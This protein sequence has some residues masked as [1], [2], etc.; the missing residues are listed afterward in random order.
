MGHLAARNAPG[1]EAG[2]ACAPA[3]SFAPTVWP[4]EAVLSWAG[5]DRST[6]HIAGRTGF[7]LTIDLKSRG[8]PKTVSATQLFLVLFFGLFLFCSPS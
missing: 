2:S 3:T 7:F 8:Q 6:P 4:C 5:L 1:P